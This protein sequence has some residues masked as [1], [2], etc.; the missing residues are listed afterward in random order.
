MAQANDSDAITSISLDQ[1]TLGIGT[2]CVRAANQYGGLGAATKAINYVEAQRYTLTINPLGS[3]TDDE[4]R[5][6]GWSTICLPYN[7]KAPTEKG[8]IVY[9][10]TAH[11]KTSDKDMVEDFYVTL[12]PVDILNK[13]K[14]YVVFGP[15]G[16]YAFKATSRSSNAPTIL[17]GNPTDSPVS[18]MNNNCYVLANKNFGL[19]FYKFTG[20]E[21]KPYKAWLPAEMVN[22][23]VGQQIVSGA[24]GIRF[25]FSDS[26][27]LPTGMHHILYG[28]Q[29]DAS[30]SSP[31]YTITGQCVSTKAKEGKSPVQRG[32]YITRGKGKRVVK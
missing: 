10:V 20:S 13:E 19:G 12:T 28:S 8:V 29:T 22:T 14:G 3:L 1:L 17:K 31:V 21:L 16:D 2:Y 4:G 15:A 25:L 24:K 27:D 5:P 32:V 23:N 26:S 18:S 7:A 11:G 30:A 6:C 9:A